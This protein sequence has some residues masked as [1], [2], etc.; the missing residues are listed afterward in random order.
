MTIPDREAVERF[1]S[2][3]VV[4]SLSTNHVL[5]NTKDT[6]R[7]STPHRMHSSGQRGVPP[8]QEPAGP[9]AAYPAEAATAAAAGGGGPVRG[10]R[11]GVPGVS[12]MGGR[13]AAIRNRLQQALSGLFPANVVIPDREFGGDDY[14]VLLELDNDV[15]NRR[16]MCDMYSD[17][18]TLCTNQLLWL[19][20]DR[21]AWQ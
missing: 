11:G 15:E 3:A 20:L 18:V 13:L 17:T 8:R 2:C 10:I 12:D 21:V 5:V 6:E 19:H 9:V 4:Y 16:G 7:A 14:E 1:C